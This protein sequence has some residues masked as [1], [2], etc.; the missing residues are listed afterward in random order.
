MKNVKNEYISLVCDRANET[1]LPSV[2]KVRMILTVIKSIHYVTADNYAFTGE[3]I[4]RYVDERRGKKVQILSTFL[5]NKNPVLVQEFKANKA[6]LDRHVG[7]LLSVYGFEI[8]YKIGKFFHQ[9]CEELSDM[10]S[11]SKRHT[12]KR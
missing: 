12:V 11:K 10:E 3:Y 6:Y 5:K 9:I 8:T 4:M 7:I 1:N 2:V